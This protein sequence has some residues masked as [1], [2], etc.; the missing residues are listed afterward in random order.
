[1][2]KILYVTSFAKDMY[3][4]SGKRLI[5]SF[6]NHNIEGDL[7]IYIYFVNRL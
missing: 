5:E 6:I 1:M 3:N 4:A 7:L 2:H